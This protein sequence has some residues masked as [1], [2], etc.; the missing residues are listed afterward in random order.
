MIKQTVNYIEKKTGIVL[1]TRLVV[2][3]W[4]LSISLLLLLASII[5][6]FSYRSS[7]LPQPPKTDANYLQSMQ[8][9]LPPPKNK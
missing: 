1:S 3:F 6:Y 9:H 8:S 2:Y 7:V 5:F 4:L